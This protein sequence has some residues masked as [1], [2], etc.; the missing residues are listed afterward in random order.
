[1]PTLKKNL[2]LR[3]QYDKFQKM[4]YESLIIV[5]LLIIDSHIDYFTVLL[6]VVLAMEPGASRML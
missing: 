1:M 2:I 6:T 4:M 5:W 3:F